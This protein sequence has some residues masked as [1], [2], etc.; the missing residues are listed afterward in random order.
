MFPILLVLTTHCLAALDP[1]LVKY[2][3]QFIEHV[4]VV[5][6]SLA[7]QAVKQAA[8]HAIFW[9][10]LSSMLASIGAVTV[11]RLLNHAYKTQKEMAEFDRDDADKVAA[12]VLDAVIIGILTTFFTCMAGQ[13]VCQLADCINAPDLVA[14]DKILLYYKM[15]FSK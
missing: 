4:K 2:I 15:L 3:D 8:A 11:Y 6:P 5:T 9:L 1:D 7:E 10:V 14:L 13:C 12:S